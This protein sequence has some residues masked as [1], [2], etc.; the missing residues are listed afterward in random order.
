MAVSLVAM[1]SVSGCFKPPSYS[2]EKTIPLPDSLSGLSYKEIAYDARDNRILVSFQYGGTL[3]IDAATGRKVSIAPECGPGAPTYDPVADEVYLS[4]AEPG[5][6]ADA[7]RDS[8][9]SVLKE[10]RMSAPQM[11]CVDTVT[12]RTY[13]PSGGGIAVLESRTLDVIDTLP[14][15]HFFQRAILC[16]NPRMHRVY[17]NR[18]DQ[19]GTLIVTDGWTNRTIATVDVSGG[20]APL[21]YNEKENKLYVLSSVRQSDYSHGP[22]IVVLDCWSNRVV[23]S[24][25]VAFYSD[26]L[27]YNARENKVYGAGRGD[28]SVIVI[29]GGS[30]RVLAKIRVPGETDD[31]VYDWISDRLY[32]CGKDWVAAIDC[33][34]DTVVGL[35][36]T[37]TRGGETRMVFCGPLNKLYYLHWN[38]CEL[39]QIDCERF[40][41]AHKTT[42]GYEVGQVFYNRGQDKVYC[43]TDGDE[44]AVIDAE[45]ESVCS[46]VPVGSSTFSALC[47]NG[48][49]TRVYCANCQSGTVIVIDG[50][51]DTV[52]ASIGVGRFPVALCYNLGHNKLYCL[53]LDSAISVIDCRTNQ[54][55]KKLWA[56]THYW[57]SMLYDSVTDRVFC[58]TGQEKKD[59]EVIDAHR[60]SVIATIPVTDEM[61]GIRGLVHDPV[62]EKLYC[63]SSDKT[64]ICVVDCRSLRLSGT[65]KTGPESW[66]YRVLPRRHVAYVEYGKGIAIVDT[67]HDY[68]IGTIE[69]SKYA[70]DAWPWHPNSFAYTPRH[71]RLF[72][73]RPQSRVDVFRE[74]AGR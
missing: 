63:A 65:V 9:L 73:A 27:R 17:W 29:D 59:V 16:C 64:E 41:A 55:V 44:V 10:V 39:Y 48:D 19:D 38:P 26:Y 61:N 56:V 13:Y 24:I 57:P 45:A 33:R 18:S 60:D 21:C 12:N 28:S 23:A 40:V 15:R 54:V 72:V 35:V 42:V 30:D 34:S 52:V 22:V 32:C 50:H 31:Y 74:D 25:P 47:S 53:G 66:F 71:R 11:V 70:N 68:I 8:V 3:V 36:R 69:L 37:S 67:D 20:A 62:H 2:V 49:G 4:R 14:S 7:H 58:I 1:V 5:A 6:R 43:T 51:A 46:F